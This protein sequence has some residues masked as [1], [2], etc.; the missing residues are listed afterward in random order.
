MDNSLEQTKV[1]GMA[2]AKYI[3]VF[4]YALLG[5]VLFGGINLV[6][7]LIGAR[8][9][10]LYPLTN[11]CQLA[12]LVLGLLGLFVFRDRLDALALAHLKFVVVATFAYMVVSNIMIALFIATLGMI[13]TYLLILVLWVIYAGSLYACFKL[14]KER[15]ELS[16]DSV[17][18]KFLSLLGR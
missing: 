6:L 16:V 4:Y 3:D 2:P 9:G 10:V 18:M 14:W 11:L 1:M 15:R 17:R 8:I 12:G 13:L 5:A 7:G